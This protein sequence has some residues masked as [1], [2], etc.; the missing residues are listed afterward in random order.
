[1]NNYDELD[2]II[3]DAGGLEQN[4][5]VNQNKDP[6]YKGPGLGKLTHKEAYGQRADLSESENSSLENFKKRVNATRREKQEQINI[7]DGW[8]PVNREEMGVRSMFYPPEW[9]FYVKPAA[10]MAIKNWTAI[11]ETRTDQVNNVFNEIVRTSVKI[12]THGV[13]QG[14][15]SQINSWDRFWFIL[16]VRELTFTKGETK[17]Q[18]EDACSECKNDITYTLTPEGLFYEFP[19]DDLIEKYWD[20]NAW[21]IDPQE[22]DVNHEPITLYTPK[23][24]RDEA[25][26]EWATARARNNQQIDETFVNF[27]VWMAPSI[28][29]NQQVRDQQ[30][31]KLYKEY[32]SWSLEMFEFMSDVIYNIT[33]NPSE[34]LRCTCPHCGMEATSTVKFPNGIKRL[35]KVETKAK[36]FGSR[37]AD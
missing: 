1:M 24:G 16:K 35:F 10:V 37:R 28:A 9:E 11:D 36:K 4:T 12:D 26:I 18:F 33:I 13:G 22:Y 7:G 20:G 5:E 3:G 19:D 31:E 15:W 30:I 25:I 2:S 23:L 21:Q 8:V 34:K 14:G 6:E 29:K 17:V 27:L 32:K